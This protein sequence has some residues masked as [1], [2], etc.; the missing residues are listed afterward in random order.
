M[1]AAAAPGAIVTWM[2]VYK[3]V[4]AAAVVLAAL[5]ASPALAAA[6]SA[7]PAASEPTASEPAKEKPLT[8]HALL[9]SHEL[10]ATI[11]VCSPKNQ[12]HTVG[13]RGSM[14]GNGAKHDKM[15]MSFRL[16]YMDTTTKQW[17]DLVSGATPAFAP[18][19]SGGAARQDGQSFQLVP[20]KTPATLRG[21][22]DF[23][24]RRGG[25]VL[26]SAARTTTA[27][28]KS[29]AGADPKSFSAATCVIS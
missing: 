23:Q 9:D 2:P 1:A 20:G 27:G 21:V 25:T 8:G 3:R 28:R 18:V 5:C 16:Q 11:D 22:V 7:S 24:W 17:V 26:E 4:T 13:V 19:G 15:F 29:L 6:S 10:W 12:P 14:P